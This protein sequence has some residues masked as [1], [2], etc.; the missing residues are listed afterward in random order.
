MLEPDSRR[1]MRR[2]TQGDQE[3]G[4]G[5]GPEDGGG[6]QVPP[7]PGE[8]HG[9]GGV[10]QQ[11]R[12][13]TEAQPVDAEGL[14]DPLHP[15]GERG[16]RVGDRGQAEDALQGQHGQGQGWVRRGLHWGRRWDLPARRA[17]RRVRRAVTEGAMSVYQQDT[18]GQDNGEG[19][20]PFRMVR[21]GYD[22]DEVDA[23]IQ[24]L[25]ARLEEAVDLYAKTEG[26]GRP[27]ARCP[28]PPGGLAVVRAARRG[29]GR[30]APGGGPVGRAAD[31]ERPASRRHDHREG[32]AAG[33]ADPSRR[34]RRSP[35]GAGAGRERSPTTSAARSRRNGRRCS[36]RPSRCASSAT[37][38]WT[39]SAGSTARSAASWNAPASSGNRR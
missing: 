38:S 31:R 34:L 7:R 4:Q 13:D 29:G 20:P 26:A 15:A 3:A 24:Q 23:Y 6:R 2:R 11:G 22:R 16:D 25:R 12:A 39:T 19:T 8:L 32:P 14:R 37:A 33:R 21:R 30:A 36:A 18:A 27:G 9:R 5:P 17:L 28:E 1:A 10:R 35:E